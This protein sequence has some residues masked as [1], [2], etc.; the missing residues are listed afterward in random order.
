MTAGIEREIVVPASIERNDVAR[1]SV[2]N[3]TADDVKLYSRR[4]DDTAYLVIVSG[5]ERTLSLARPSKP[6]EV[7]CWL[8][9]VVDGEVVLLWD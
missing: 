8:K 6:G 5:Y 3:A 2:G 7:I 1:L 9:P 4:G